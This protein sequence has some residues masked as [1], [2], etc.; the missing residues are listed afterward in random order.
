MT[1]TITARVKTTFTAR[2]GRDF[3]ITITDDDVWRIDVAA[4]IDPEHRAPR[5]PARAHIWDTRP[6]MHQ[7]A[8]TER[9]ADAAN[10][11][12]W[13]AYHAAEIAA[14]RDVLDQ[15][16]THLGAAGT[17]AT[18]TRNAGCGM[19]PC[20]PGFLL[21]APVAFRGVEGRSLYISAA[22]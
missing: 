7:P 18:F 21:D 20:S 4:G 6:D 13:D 1:T 9:G 14:M 15:A 22:K 5:A 2:D 19:C 17:D 16:L 3:E 11:A 10:D 8:Y 12:A